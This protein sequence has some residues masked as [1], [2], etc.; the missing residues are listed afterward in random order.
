MK[1]FS[2]MLTVLLTLA[3][4]AGTTSALAEV[5]YPLEDTKPITY[6]L[7]LNA[8]VAASSTSLNETQYAAG[9][10]ERTGVAVEFIHP[11]V[12]QQGEQFNLM[13]AS[14]KM[15][16]IVEHNWVQGYTGGPANAIANGLIVE[17]NDYLEEFAPDY[18]RYLQ[19]NPHIDKM[20]KTD[21]GQYYGFTMFILDEKMTCSY[22]PFL[23]ADWLEELGLEAPTT[24]DEWTTVLTAFKEKGAEVPFTFG[25][26][27]SLNG[28]FYG[29]IFVGA[30][31]TY[32]DYYVDGGKVLYGPA[33]P[34]YKDFV[35]K[36]NEWYNAGLI[37]ASFASVDN[38]ERDAN[39]LS[40][41]S[42]ATSGWGNA[43][44]GSLTR[45]FPEHDE[46]AKLVGVPYPALEEGQRP[47][48][49]QKR[50]PMDMPTTVAINAKSENI[51]EIIK[52]LNYGYTEEGYLYNNFGTEGETYDMVD[53]YPLMKEF[54][55][56]PAEGSMGQAWAKYARSPYSGPFRQSPEYFEQYLNL[57]V[58]QEA[59]ALWAATD[60]LDHVLPPVSISVDDGKTYNKIAADMNNYAFEWTVQAITGAIS[61][62]EFD[63][64]IATLNDIGLEE[65]TRIQQDAY[66]RY[67]TR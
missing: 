50:F 17:L 11:A 53:G 32:T 40:A 7:V 43:N 41:R 42:G 62:D 8:N 48:F 19:E 59:V 36:M 66:D 38:A 22:G 23:R 1:L 31:G 52:F 3:L 63:D 29:G 12:G 16:D 18:L 25:D 47:M 30:F 34:G 49:G 35:V 26:N 46:N 21:Q 9:L 5:T 37:D 20:V 51:E 39:I 28:L 61:L 15:P 55:T 13:I 58:L 14:G 6:W 64:F 27:A 65:A 2:R 4:L 44:L 54:I 24:I 33:Q 60:A 56:N 10:I 57:P 45:A 67:L